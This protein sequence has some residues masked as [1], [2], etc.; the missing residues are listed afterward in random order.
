MEDSECSNHFIFLGEQIV[1][2]EEVK[3]CNVNRVMSHSL[4][5]YVQVI[6]T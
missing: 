3:N 5:F 1:K 2:K 4:V 6:S